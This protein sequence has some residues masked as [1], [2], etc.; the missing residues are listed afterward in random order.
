MQSLFYH[1]RVGPA[2]AVGFRL[3]KRHSADRFILAESAWTTETLTRQGEWIVKPSVASE[4]T[5][6][7]PYIA[8]YQSVLENEAMAVLNRPGVNPYQRTVCMLLDWLLCYDLGLVVWQNEFEYNY[9]G[10]SR[11]CAT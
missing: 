8:M 7:Q 3:D 5:A 10:E 11:N 6:L 9:Y 1:R 2:S 4:P